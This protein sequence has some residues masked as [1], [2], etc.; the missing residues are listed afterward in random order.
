MDYFSFPKKK[1]TKQK[2]NPEDGIT[3][4]YSTNRRWHE[5]VSFSKQKMI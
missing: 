4:S 1:K 5:S 3:L 2:K